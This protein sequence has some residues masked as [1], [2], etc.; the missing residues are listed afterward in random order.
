MNIYDP[1]A[2]ALGVT[3]FSFQFNISEYI[4]PNCNSAPGA[5]K[6]MKHNDLSK[7]QISDKSKKQ[8]ND[9]RKVCDQD[10][11]KKGVLAKYGVENIRHLKDECPHCKKQGQY[12]AL[13]RWHYS[14]CN[15]LKK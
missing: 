3:P 8:W 6:G 14:N 5:F 9:G 15:K 10:K 1:I 7:K 13:K 12:I 2:E 4:I 11:M